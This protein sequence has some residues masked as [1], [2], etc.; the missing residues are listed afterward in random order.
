MISQS[1]LYHKNC[2]NKTEF[3][4]ILL[5]TDNFYINKKG[6][7]TFRR[8]RFGA[9]QLGA[10]PFRRRTFRRRFLIYFYFSSYEE[11]TMKQAISWMPLSANL[12]KLESSILPRAKRA[13]NRNNV[14]AEQ[15]IWKKKFWRRMV[16]AP[17]CPAP[18]CPAPKCPAPKRTRPEK[19]AS[20]NS[21]NDEGRLA[22]AKNHVQWTSEQWEK[23]KMIYFAI[24]FNCGA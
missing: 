17:K 5:F 4:K 7:G 10:V 2:E 16:P 9:G 22:W 8:R 15:R 11:K 3:S 19:E 12:L 20:F 6:G 18:K 14:A 21:A 1:F 24:Q 13:T 23:V